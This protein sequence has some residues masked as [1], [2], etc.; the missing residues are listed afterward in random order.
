MNK[1][2]NF[3]FAETMTTDQMIFEKA[4]KKQDINNRMLN[5]FKSVAIDCDINK[6]NG[7]KCAEWSNN[8]SLF[9]ENI[10]QTIEIN[11]RKYH[12][13]SHR[14]KIKLGNKY[15]FADGCALYD[16][17]SNELFCVAVKT[18]K[19]FRCVKAPAV[20][21]L[22]DSPKANICSA[23]LEDFSNTGRIS[24]VYL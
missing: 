7:V 6:I 1:N 20:E 15:T 3:K 9:D 24:V 12:V 19:G 11:N 23:F 10:L 18:K 4:K 16:S 21:L 5:V 17:E 22:E 14:Y 2:Y 13:E 8:V